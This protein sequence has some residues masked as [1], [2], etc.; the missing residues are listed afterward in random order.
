MRCHHT[1][2]YG[3][4]CRRLDDTARMRAHGTHPPLVGRRLAGSLWGG[5]WRHFDQLGL[6]GPATFLLIY[7]SLGHSHRG[8]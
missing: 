7:I 8:T 2:E 6:H 4:M 3:S 5:T 1:C